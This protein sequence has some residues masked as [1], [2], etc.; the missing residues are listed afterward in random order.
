M[1]EAFFVTISFLILLFSKLDGQYLSQGSCKNLPDGL[2]KLSHGVDITRLTL[3]P[4]D[5]SKSDGFRGKI[6]D[7]TC[8]GNKTWKDPFTNEIYDIPEQ[9]TGFYST[10]GGWRQVVSNICNTGKEMRQEMA[11]VCDIEHEP[12][13]F[14]QS[15]VF[16]NALIDGMIRNTSLKLA[17]VFMAQPLTKVDFSPRF[18]YG[19]GYNMNFVFES[20]PLN[21]TANPKPYYDF[22]KTFG[23]HMFSRASLGG[24]VQGIFKTK[25]NYYWLQET[26]ETESKSKFIHLMI[27]QGFSHLN[28]PPKPSNSFQDGSEYQIESYGRTSQSPSLTEQRYIGNVQEAIISGTLTPIS[29]LFYD[30]SKKKQMISAVESYLDRAYLQ[31]LQSFLKS[32]FIPFKYENSSVLLNLTGTLN[33]ETQKLIPNHYTTL[34]LGRRIEYELLTPDWWNE[35]QLCFNYYA[36]GDKS[37]CVGYSNEICAFVGDSTSFYSD[38]TNS[39]EGGCLMKWALKTP[40]YISDWFRAVQI[41]FKYSNNS[42]ADYTEVCA[43]VNSFTPAFKDD[44]GSRDIRVNY[45]SWMFKVPAYAPIW[46]RKKKMCLSWKGNGN[47]CG[48]EDGVDDKLCAG[49]NEWTP[50]Y[51][52]A[53][54]DDSSCRM[55]WSISH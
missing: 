22:I 23:T 46:L 36:D 52:D 3:W 37:Q 49:V 26:L 29:E 19:S 43:P 34:E 7:Y 15:S 9:V 4:W 48:G 50:R 51:K 13:M 17:H 12:G 32:S 28:T 11:T 47:A 41:C 42:I 24:I 39:K 33:N 53:T 10:R 16:E 21:F 30:S 2:A 8:K 14:S 25:K 38:I 27:D 1:F 20:L 35:V 55:S 6:V 54:D 31:E 45:E 18:I 5:S 44:T 40:F